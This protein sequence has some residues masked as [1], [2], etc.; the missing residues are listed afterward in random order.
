MLGVW[1]AY[2]GAKKGGS[3]VYMCERRACAV[4]VVAGRGGSDDGGGVL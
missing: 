1:V 2:K 3:Q 4:Q